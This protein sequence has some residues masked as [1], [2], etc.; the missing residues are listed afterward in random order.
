MSEAGLEMHLQSVVG[1]HKNISMC[2]VGGL[3]PAVRRLHVLPVLLWVFSG[4]KQ[5]TDTQVGLIRSIGDPILT[6][7]VNVRVNDCL[8]PCVSPMTHW[9]L[10]LSF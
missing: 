3:G 7:G 8:S 1:S 9:C 6:T 4:S 10:D 5:S 2:A